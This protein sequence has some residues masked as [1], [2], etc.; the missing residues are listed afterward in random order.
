MCI[1]FPYSRADLYNIIAVRR[2]QTFNDVMASAGRNPSSLGCEQCK[3]CIGSILATLY[4]QHVMDKPLHPLQ[5]TNDKFLAN[6]Q[7]NGTFSVMPRIAGGEITPDRLIVIGRVAKKFGLYTKITGAQRID[8]FG[9]RKQDLLDIWQELVDAGMESGHAYAKS[10][11]T[12]KSCVG[13]SWCRFGLMDSV[14]MAIR[15]ENRYK[16]IRSPHKIKGAVSGC[17]RECAE[18]QNKE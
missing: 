10:L 3:P 4:N 15:L 11:R 16:G 5:D 14:G 12:I 17:V 13:T 8:M 2:L 18:A 7:R 6:I 1:H 9:A